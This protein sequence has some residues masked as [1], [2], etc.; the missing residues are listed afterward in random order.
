MSR[1]SVVLTCKKC[2]K[3][4]THIKHNC[5]NSTDARKY[6]EWA[7]KNVDTCPDCYKVEQEAKKLAERAK[8]AAGN[9]EGAKSCPLEFP[10]L[11][12]SEKQIAWA[13][14][15]RNGIISAM[16]DRK[17]KWDM[18]INTDN[19]TVKAEMV[20]LMEPSA[21][22]WID[23]RMKKVFDFCIGEKY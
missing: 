12:G 7:K 10:V 9:S 11:I 13:T 2:G 23:N 5:Y 1:A 20:K 15:L 8:Q 16:V 19:Q 14:D 17:A 6:E 18:L 21:K 4:F 3:E 22:W